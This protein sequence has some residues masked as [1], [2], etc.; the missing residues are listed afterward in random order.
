MESQINEYSYEINLYD[1]WKVVAKRKK[2]I[3]G[4]F[5]IFVIFSIIIVPLLPKIYRGE[6]VLIIQPAVNI[7]AKDLAEFVGK[8]DQEKKAA[9]LPNTHTL[10]GDIKLSTFKDSK[11]KISLIIEA[12]DTN[13]IQPA[14]MEIIEYINNIDL[15]KMNVKEERERLL[16]RSH[17]LSIVIAAS[18]E[19]LDTYRKQ[20]IGGK[21]SLVGFNPIEL[22]KKI[23][24]IKVEKLTVDQAI[25]RLKNGAE[26]AN[27]LYVVHKPVKPNK[28]MIV[29]LTGAVGLF[30]G[31]FFAFFMD[32]FEKI[33]SRN[34]S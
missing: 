24:D 18:S 22:N 7:T 2:L 34:S 25:Q 31:I 33:K 32:H 20:L 17:E 29:A 19:L 21:L 26:I 8:I 28:R 4:F 23:S 5:L 15:V 10:I 9:V 16:R 1:L 11:D 30:L 13:A 3:I 12:K 6:T 14:L 27:P